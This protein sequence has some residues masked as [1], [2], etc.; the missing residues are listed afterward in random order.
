MEDFLD[1]IS[2]NHIPSFLPQNN[3]ILKDIQN[4]LR[5]KIEEILAKNIEVLDFSFFTS[6]QNK[7]PQ[8]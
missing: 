8:N 4:L 7:I 6:S 5:K 2:L 1:I 3:P